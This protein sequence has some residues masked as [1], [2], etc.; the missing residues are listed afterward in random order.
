MLIILTDKKDIHA[1]Q[2]ALEQTVRKEFR[3][4]KISNIGY[5]GGMRSDAEI[6]SDGI[7]WCMSENHR[8]QETASPRR[9]NWFGKMLDKRD[10]EITVELNTPY[11]GRNDRVAGFFARDE[12]T[13]IVYL[14]HSGKI[15]GGRKG[16][17]RN[18]FLAWF[19]E[20]LHVA[21]DIDGNERAGVIV[22]PVEGE[23]AVQSLTRFIDHVSMFKQ[24]VRTGM[25]ETRDFKKRE[26]EYK[27]FYQE[28]SGRR[29]GRR[30]SSFDYFSNHGL[31][32]D[33]L[34]EWRESKGLSASEKIRKNQLIDLGV[35]TNGKL[36]ELYEVKTSVDRQCL[37]SAI[38]QLVVHSA[39]K[40]C[41]RTLVVPKIDSLPED[42]EKVLD[43]LGIERLGF[44]KKGKKFVIEG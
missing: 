36:S 28:S 8:S 17:G 19:N 7:Y 1:A 41:R 2:S 3:Q 25:M 23:M 39:D 22:M 26:A 31:V 14:L 9:L 30:K 43:V 34:K 29:K 27:D 24:Q 10:Q 32:V 12:Q 44:I 5:S 13:G 11:K 4:R 21:A 37:Y 15:G 35:F 33:A 18:A 40:E 16:V 20:E 38:G 42:F 6:F